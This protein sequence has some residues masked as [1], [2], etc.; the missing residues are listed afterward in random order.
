MKRL[1]IL[2][3][4]VM[5]LGNVY[6]QII[7]NEL[8][9]YPANWFPLGATT[10][11]N[12]QQCFGYGDFDGD[13]TKEMVG[14]FSHSWPGMFIHRYDGN[15]WNYSVLHP[16]F[17]P[18]TALHIKGMNGTWPVKGFTSGDFDGDGRYEIITYADQIMY[19][20]AHGDT[21]YPFPGCIY[22]DYKTDSELVANPLFW[23]SWGEADAS[24]IVSVLRVTPVT[25]GFRDTIHNSGVKDFL[26]NTL[27]NDSSRFKGRMYILE[28]PQG[29]FNSVDYRYIQPGILDTG[30]LF[31][32]EPFYLHHLY[33]NQGG[34]DTEISFTPSDY[35]PASSSWCTGNV[36]DYD[37]DGLIDLVV[38]VTYQKGDTPVYSS[39]RV[40]HRLPSLPGRRYRFEEA[41]RRD[42]PDVNFWELVPANLNGSPND[43][44]EA[45]I[46]N[47]RIWG[48]F[49]PFGVCGVATLQ[50]IADTFQLL[51]TYAYNPAPVALKYKSTYS[52]A[53]AIDADG[54]GYDDAAVVMVRTGLHDDIV[55]FRNLNGQ[56]RTFPE[57]FCADNGNSKVLW[58]D[59]AF[60][61]DLH[62]GDFDDDGF[63]ELGAA[64]GLKLYPDSQ[65]YS[66]YFTDALWQTAVPEIFE[67][68]NDIIAFP[69]PS[70]GCFTL[71]YDL[72]SDC[73]I[74]IDLL[75]ISG[76]RI[77]NIYNGFAEKGTHTI[78]NKFAG[79]KT[80]IY[81]CRMT[82]KNNC[83]TIKIVI[84]F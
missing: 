29:T 50:Y 21:V 24:S 73:E 84:T 62:T 6:G 32:R 61:W 81:L 58:E 82:T 74:Q 34:Y 56:I 68:Q 44:K 80:G 28:Q 3:A 63:E 77:Q 72:T 14:S 10:L 13:G 26:V 60:T 69:N 31:M 49:N 38:S 1:F 65:S 25:A 33:V 67:N 53:A 2:L 46:M 54:D 27:W 40:Y 47:A 11:H 55:L 16:K 41:F 45:W 51:G 52:S 23:G 18:D 30:N 37:K 42:I 71:K 83:K 7:T 22:I 39:V 48:G 79:L 36:W 78:I 75:D 20:L 5:V 76:K 9:S 17:A 19:P 43:G 8:T 66:I 57:L 4:T 70:D 15:Q 35:P 64:E 59:H 12:Y